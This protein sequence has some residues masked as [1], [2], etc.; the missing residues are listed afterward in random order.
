MEIA[1]SVSGLHIKNEIEQVDVVPSPQ[2]MISW[3]WDM[4]PDVLNTGVNTST[5]GQNE[6]GERSAPQLITEPSLKH[7]DT[8]TVSIPQTRMT[9]QASSSSAPQRAKESEESRQESALLDPA[10]ASTIATLSSMTH[11]PDQGMHN[12]LHEP[13][14]RDPSVSHV[15]VTILTEDG[16]SKSSQI[17]EYSHGI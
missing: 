16:L 6:A 17:H 7:Q 12:G 13:E 9:R 15:P 14:S 8:I 5:L 11:K 1:G 3:G 2:L 4:G 10:F